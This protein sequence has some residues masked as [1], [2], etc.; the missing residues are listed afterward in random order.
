MKIPSY[1]VNRPSNPRTVPSY[2]C[3]R[4][5]GNAAY[6]TGQWRD[7]LK[8]SRTCVDSRP[9][10]F[11]TGPGGDEPGETLDL[12]CMYMQLRGFAAC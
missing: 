3:R 10:G 2:P 11:R 8:D 4:C 1:D 12:L 9:I 5:N 6:E 7:G